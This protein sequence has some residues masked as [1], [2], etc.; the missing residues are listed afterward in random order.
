MAGAVGAAARGAVEADER[1]GG[2]PQA[3][4]AGTQSMEGGGCSGRGMGP[5]D[6][7]PGEGGGREEAALLS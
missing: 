4:L 7:S 2:Q 5:C 6:F 3:D 1:G